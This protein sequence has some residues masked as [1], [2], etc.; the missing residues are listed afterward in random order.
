MLKRFGREY[1]VSVRVTTFE[2]LEEAFSKLST[3]GL[4]FDV[5]FTTPDWVSR[6]VGR[7]LVQPIN[8]DLVPNLTRTVW[9][10]AANPFYDVGPRYTVP[11]VVYTTGIG[12]RNDIVTDIDPDALPTVWDALWEAQALQRARPAPQRSA[13]GDR[14]GDHAPG[15]LDI[16]TESAPVIDAAVESLRELNRDVRVKVAINAYEALPAGRT[17]LG[18]VW[19]GDMLNAAISYLPPDLGPEALSYTYQREG[20]PVFNDCI[21]V[22]AA[23]TK[24]VL[25]HRLMDFLLEPRNAL[26]NFAGYVG[27]QPPLNAIT[28]DDADRRR[29]HPAQPREHDRDRARRTRTAT[30]SWR[31]P[32]P[33]SAAGTAAGPASRRASGVSPAGSGALLAAPGL[34]WLVVFFLVAFYAVVAVGMGNVTTLFEPVPHWNP[35]DWNVGYLWQAIENVLPGGTTWPVF[36]RTLLYVGRSDGALAA[37]RLPGGVLRRPPRRALD[38]ASCSSLLVLPFWISYIMRMFAWTNLLAT[39]GYAARALNALSIDSLFGALGLMEGSDWLGGQPITVILALV[40][41][42]VPFL[43]IPLYASLDRL[44]QPPD[45]GVAR[46]RGVAGRVRSGA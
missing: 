2:T 17:V 20:G 27:Y 25:A 33:V 37:D 22:A 4:E 28:A 19:S 8:L 34:L 10:E 21:A 31:S 5:I 16:N 13:R 23:A 26:E 6:L 30:P 35:L 24:P 38:A 32:R 39:D 42:Y 9:P 11:Y 36:V 14:R 40:Y 18:Q 3:G 15:S 41:G 45:R 7:R 46:P 12:W 29:G 1:G 44:D 43:I